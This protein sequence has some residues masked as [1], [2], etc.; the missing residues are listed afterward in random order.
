MFAT[1]SALQQLVDQWSECSLPAEQWTH[2][3]YVAVAS[4]LAWNN[5]LADTYTLMK[6][7]LRRFHEANGTPDTDERGDHET[8]TRFW[9]TMLFFRI[10]RGHF[11]TCVQA[12]HAMVELYG[13]DNR[14]E[15]A[16]YSFDVLKSKEAKRHWIAPDVPGVIALE[17]FRW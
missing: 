1:E 12:V 8:L 15:R 2:A 9:T 4:W 10:H 16:Y 7:G 14:A 3:A 13:E 6:H 11:N 17:A 5:T